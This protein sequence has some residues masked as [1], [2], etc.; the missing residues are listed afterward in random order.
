MSIEKAERIAKVIAHAGLCSRRDAE[1][2]ISEGRVQVNGTTL[3]SPAVTVSAEDIITVDGKNLRRE[4]RQKRARLWVYHKPKDQI[5]THKDPQGRPTVFE[6][7]PK[8]MPRVVSVGRLDFSTEGL[9]LLTTDGEL[10]RMLELPSSKL[11][12]IYRV[13][14]KGVINE[15][16]LKGLRKGGSYKDPK[17]GKPVAFGPVRAQRDVVNSK[18]KDSSNQWIIMEIREGKNREI[19]NICASL[20]LTVSRLIRTHYGPFSLEGVVR[21]TV[22][23]VPADVLHLLITSLTEGSDAHHRRKISREIRRREG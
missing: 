23:E 19:R 1:R 4:V 18:K 8:Q 11:R 22:A 14:V 2:W 5:T 21:G 3:T 16:A 12:R 15:E 13:R 20:G 6:H 7:L 9:L 17:T 10:A